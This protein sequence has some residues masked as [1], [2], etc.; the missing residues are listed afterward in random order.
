MVEAHRRILIVDDN[1]DIHTDFRKVLNNTTEGAAD[2]LAAADDLFGDDPAPAATPLPGFDLSFANQGATAL[3]LVRQARRE[4]RPFAMAF[5][6]VRMPPGWDGIETVHR[7]WQVDPDL[8]IVFCTAYSDR[9]WQETTDILG[10][11]DRFLIL[12]K[13]FDNVEVRQLAVA[14]TEKWRIA[15]ELRQVVHGLADQ[16]E[17][18]THE[19]LA[20]RDLT[21]FALAELAESRDLEFL[22]DLYRSAPLHDIGKVGIPDA[23]LLKPGRLTPEEFE[24]MKHHSVIG[25]ETLE[26]VV[27]HSGSG[28]FLRMAAEIARYHHERFNGTGYPDGLR[29]HQIPLSARIVALADVWDALTTARVYKPAYEPARAREII[30]SEEGQHFDPVVVEAYCRCYPQFLELLAGQCSLPAAEACSSLT[31]ASAPVACG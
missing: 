8:Q 12:K 22:D 4:G 18:R 19:V 27:R 20:T 5:V 7:I 31:S 25:A 26:N 15:G 30:M 17:Q 13:P 14:M 1:E 3:E 16:V 9:S 6:D 29:G 23:I 28:G 11:T 10:V 2:L 21:V 24:V